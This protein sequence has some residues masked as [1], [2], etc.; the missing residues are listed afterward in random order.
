MYMSPEQAEG[1]LDVDARADVFSLGCVFFEC[2]TGAPP[3]VSDSITGT[4]ARLRSDDAVDV[5]AKCAGLPARL[6]NLLRRVLAKRADER[7]DMAEIV[8]E[9]DGIT[10]RLGAAGILPTILKERCAPK[11]ASWLVANGERRLVAVIVVSPRQLRAP[12]LDLV[13]STT[14]DLGD[15]LARSL[16]DA[17]FDESRLDHLARD[18]APFGAAIRRLGNGSFVVTLT[19]EA[20]SIPLDLA[21]RA[22]RCALKIKR[23]RPTSALGIS[24]GHAIQDG[25]LHTNHI[26][27][28]AAELVSLQHAG[29]IHISDEIKGLLDAR[30]ETAAL[31]NGPSRLLFE[32][33]LREAPRTVLRKEIPCL[34]R[35]REIREL[36]SLFDACVKE[37]VAQLAILT[38]A[39]G[40]G[41]SR[42][43]YDF[44]ERLRDSGK[45]FELLLG[46]GDLMRADIALGLLAQALRGAAGIS[47][48]E[49]TDIQCKRLA[50]RTSR[51][52]PA[53]KVATTVA[54]LGEI[55]NVHFSDGELPQLQTARRD[56]R[57][58]ADQT[59]AAWVDWL[60]VETEH[61]PVFLLLEDLHWAD[62]ASLNYIDSA[63]RD[64]RKKPLL[65]LALARPEVDDRFFGLW[66]DHYVQRI[67]LSPLGKRAG[68]EF[69]RRALGE[70]SPEKM[71]WL[72]DHAQGNPSRLEELVHAAANDS[73]P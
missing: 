57:L 61:Q 47:G 37:S 64:L 69:I 49:P 39:A 14:A 27:E 46:R 72:L 30:F 10:D 28:R 12:P 63:L 73:L 1:A 40:S 71:A 62:S 32:K 54:F 5:Q 67:S 34:G 41:K 17:E 58:M 38:G 19:G 52:L 50:A 25:D 18:L 11:D 53:E 44:L 15:F 29:A 24:L 68:Q 45:S 35:E 21:V 13:P 4:F 43:V 33:S 60:A 59:R 65:V 55:A 7:P 26:V 51:F 8:A 56:A 20:R 31:Q 66:R 9:L 70:V 23:A 6:R 42:L 3:F 2:L 36:G 16:S 22:A 48:T